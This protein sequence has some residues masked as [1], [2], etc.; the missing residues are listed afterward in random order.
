MKNSFHGGNVKS[1]KSQC[2]PKNGIEELP[3]GTLCGIEELPA[4]TLHS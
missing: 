4:G 1:R 2:G 3:V